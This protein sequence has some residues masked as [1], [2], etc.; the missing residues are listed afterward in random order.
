[1]A[2]STAPPGQGEL[3]RES[4]GLA[5]AEAGVALSGDQVDLLGR[6]L[7]LL[8]RW[9]RVHSL[10]A[11][12]EP[13]EQLIRHLLDSLIAEQALTGA[14]GSLVGVHV[15]DVG[16]GMGSPGIV[17][18]AVMPESKFDLIERQQ[19]KAAFLRHVVG[20]LGWGGRV[21]VAEGDVRQLWGRR[22]YGLITSRAFAGLEEFLRLTVNISEPGTLW[23]AMIG[24]LK[25]DV[26]EQLLLKMNSQTVEIHLQNL[27]PLHVP[28]LSAERHLLIARRVT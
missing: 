2:R 23:A 20:Q 16:S 3:D 27:I 15:A 19:K 5:C 24:R 21:Q 17:W 26:S 28:G 13:R 6:Y 22:C 10:T 11:I 7:E 8:N 25:K 4:V 9:N 14:V 18:A 12:D 1:L